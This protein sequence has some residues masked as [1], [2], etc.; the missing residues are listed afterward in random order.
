MEELGALLNKHVPVAQSALNSP[1][2][3]YI[4]DDGRRYLYANPNEKFDMIFIDPLWSFT[5]GH[6]NL[7]SQEAM[8]LYSKHLTTG[9]IFCAWVNEQHF[10][11]KTAATI[12]PHSDFFGDYLVN[13]SQ[14]IEYDMTYMRQSYENYLATQSIHLIPDAAAAMNPDEIL[15]SLRTKQAK[16]LQN[17]ERVPA[18]T[19]M[20]PWLEYYYFC[21]PQFL[22]K[23]S[24][25]QLKYCY[26]RH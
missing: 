21:P 19:D 16:T 17:E 25:P 7:Y 8:S 18:L 13:S 10:I 26:S 4:S 1:V 23:L 9:G 24:V 5:A 14:P 12:F 20:T 22:E 3:R 11:P 15:A 6:N 2:T